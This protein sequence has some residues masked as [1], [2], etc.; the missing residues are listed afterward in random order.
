[1]DGRDEMRLW[2]V[3]ARF[4]REFACRIV[5][6]GPTRRVNLWTPDG[7]MGCRCDRPIRIQPFNVAIR[8]KNLRGEISDRK[9]F[10]SPSQAIFLS[11]PFEIP[12]QNI[13]RISFLKQWVYS[14]KELN[15]QSHT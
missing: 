5:T 12:V 14:S 4:S 13:Y 7:L 8:K 11:S 15:E 1:V 2:W 6:A 10:E 9:I 3:P